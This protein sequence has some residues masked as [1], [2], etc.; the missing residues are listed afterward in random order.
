MRSGTWVSA[1][2]AALVTAIAALAGCARM[3]AALGQQWIVVQF[4]PGTSVATAR[5]VTSACSR[6]P[7]L[8]LDGPVR[9][10]PAEPSVVD[11]V[12]YNATQA[13]NAD[14]ARL[15]RCLQRFT[16]AVQGETL[17]QPGDS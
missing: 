15:E 5:H 8:R 14:M 3:N 6:V 9:G 4:A 10:S 16:P 12:R 11:S 7:H 13:S 1:A 2:I 17:I